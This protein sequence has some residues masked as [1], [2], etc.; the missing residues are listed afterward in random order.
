[1]ENSDVKIKELVFQ[2][3]GK[4][5]EQAQNIGEEITMQVAERLPL[6]KQTRKLDPL[7]LRVNV[8]EEASQ[9]TM[10]KLISE[11]IIRGLI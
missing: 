6:T 10:M 3:P 2:L 9:S 11:A 7:T 1:M 5:E 4:Y 8:P